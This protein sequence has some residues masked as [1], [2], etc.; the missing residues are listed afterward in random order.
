MYQISSST[1]L[2]T[3]GVV[4]SFNK[5]FKSFAHFLIP[6]I[7]FLLLSFVS[8]IYLT[9]YTG[10]SSQCHQAKL[11]EIKGSTQIRKGEVKLSLFEKDLI[12]Y[13]ENLIEPTKKVHRT[14]EFNS[15]AAYKINIKMKYIFI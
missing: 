5:M 10:G 12:I 3:C 11:K 9:L 4:T 13:V 14:D 2:P 6:L 1:S 8:Y 15:I 7:I